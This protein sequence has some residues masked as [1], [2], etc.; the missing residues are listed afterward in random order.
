MRSNALLSGGAGT[1]VKCGATHERK[2]ANKPYTSQVAESHV[3][4]LINARHKRTKKMQWTREGAHHVLQ[5]RALMAS[6]EWESKGQGAVLSALGA[7]A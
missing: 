5:I 3:D 6:D 7:V 1:T 4:A 2:Q